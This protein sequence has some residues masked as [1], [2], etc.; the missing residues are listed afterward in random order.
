MIS[1]GIEPSSHK[2][3]PHVF[4]IGIGG[5]GM[6][7]LAKLL[8]HRGFTVSGSDREHDRGQRVEFYDDLK[9][10]G[11]RLVPQDG[12]GIDSHIDRVVY[13][14]AIE[15]GIPDLE[16]SKNLGLRCVHRSDELAGQL[17]NYRSIAVSGTSGKTTLTALLAWILTRSGMDPT[18]LAGAPIPGFLKGSDSD[19][20]GGYSNL[21]VFEADESD[22]S[23]LRY[24][25]SIGVIHNISKDHKDMSELMEIFKLFSRQIIETIALNADCP[26]AMKLEMKFSKPVTYGFDH[27]AVFKGENRFLHGWS[28]GFSVEGSKIQVPLP[29]YHNAENAL[30]A[31][32]VARILSISSETISKHI[33]TFPGVRRRFERIGA[34]FGIT[35]VD[36]YAHNPDK[37]TASLKTARHLSKRIIAVYQP[38]GFGPTRFLKN[39]LISTFTRQLEPRDH[40]LLAPIF[41]AGGTVAKDIR[42]EDLVTGI[43]R[44][45]KS[46]QMADR[47]A[48]PQII[49]E[50][51]HPGDMVLVMGARDP[52]LPLLSRRILN[53]LTRNDSDPHRP[54]AGSPES[55]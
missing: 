14:T 52:S 21:M 4:M 30:A 34:V 26:E 50:L 49:R 29:G 45:H 15:S 36:D 32:A 39:D 44:F 51:A 7:A 19:F 28:S 9:K 48:I 20:R 2:V 25:P 27:D 6:N 10:F 43:S 17:D 5:S 22:G 3:P 11:I 13:S 35:V 23:L 55:F 24:F 47:D 46:V 1:T 38:H 18:V 37:I 54:L 53:R 16:V 31:Y 42:S 8:R 41:Y 12:S 33:G 40:L